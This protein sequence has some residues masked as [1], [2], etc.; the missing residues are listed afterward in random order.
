MRDT[1][2]SLIWITD[3]LKE[4]N[5]PYQITG[6][7]AARAYGATRDLW[8]IDIDIP[9]D[10]F[11]IVKEKVSEF[12]IFGPSRIKEKSWD[13]L[14]MTLHHHGQEIDLGGA[15]QTKIFN[16]STGKWHQ[17]FTDFSKS[18]SIEI[19]GSKVPVIPRN[20]LLA[21]KK[22]LARPVDLVDI[23]EIEVKNEEKR[24]NPS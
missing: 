2:T 15:Y 5:V 4:L 19:L 23:R 22:I 11:E 13:L 14:L 12:I 9:E 6:G 7:L 18:V 16:Q 24:N 3:I 17:L 8:D 10:K 20:D 21:Y 1:K